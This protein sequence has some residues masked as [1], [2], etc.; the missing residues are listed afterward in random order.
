[1]TTATVGRRFQVVIPREERRRLHLRPSSKVCVEA[2]GG[3]LLICPMTA[4]GLRG[5]G[6]DLADR[7]DAA[8]YVRKL[9]AEWERRE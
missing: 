3:Y 9:R 2:R 5:I 6:S 8:D 1:M 4:K 7:T